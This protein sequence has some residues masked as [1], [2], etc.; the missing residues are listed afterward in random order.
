MTDE[1]G[2]RGALAAVSLHQPQRGGESLFQRQKS[3]TT[4]KRQA[5]SKKS[6]RGLKLLELWDCLQPRISGLCLPQESQATS[7]QRAAEACASTSTRG[8]WK[9]EWRGQGQWQRGEKKPWMWLEEKQFEQMQRQL[10]GLQV[11]K[12]THQGWRW[13]GPTY[14]S[15]GGG[16]RLAGRVGLVSRLMVWG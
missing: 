7:L 16:S 3:K 1:A 14:Q 6:T 8:L 4:M 11:W 10:L 12:W 2:Q 9:E 13:G 5:R 15:P